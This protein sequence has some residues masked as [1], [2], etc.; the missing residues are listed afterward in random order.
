MENFG[1]KVGTAIEDE[2]F[3]VDF[4]RDDVYDE[5]D[6]IVELSPKIYEIGGSLVTFAKECNSLW[7]VTMSLCRRP[8]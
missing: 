4:F 6:N 7:D 8:N 5:D 1:E 3:F 2:R